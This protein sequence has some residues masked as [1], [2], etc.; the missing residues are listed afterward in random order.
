[1]EEYNGSNNSRQVY[2]FIR[3]LVVELLSFV[4][5]SLVKYLGPRPLLDK[6]RK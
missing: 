5:F 4:F 3:W 2:P 1:M 6:T